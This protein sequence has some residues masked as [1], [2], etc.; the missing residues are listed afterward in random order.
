MT[1]IR[2]LSSFDEVT[3]AVTDSRYF[4]RVNVEWPDRPAMVSW[5]KQ[6]CSGTVCIWNGTSTPDVGSTN[7]ASVLAPNISRAY[8]IFDNHADCEMFL[9]KYT[10][11]H[12]AVYFGSDVS[13][14]YHDSRSIN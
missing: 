11:D 1:E 4:V 9:L 2:Y 12:N 14:A 10:S 3:W 5:F 7:W 8:I 13:R 6:C